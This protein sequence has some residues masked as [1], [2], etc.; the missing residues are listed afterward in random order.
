MRKTKKRQG[1]THIWS[2]FGVNLSFNPHF[3]SRVHNSVLSFPYLL[4]GYL[5]YMCTYLL[6][7]TVQKRVFLTAHSTVQDVSGGGSRHILMPIVH[8]SRVSGHHLTHPFFFGEKSWIKPRARQRKGGKKIT[9][10]CTLNDDV[11]FFK[12]SHPPPTQQ[13][14]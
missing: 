6:L 8:T 1:E 13:Q 4:Y 12:N 5:Y 11:N 9:T 14:T 2:K 10:M 3:K 7:Q